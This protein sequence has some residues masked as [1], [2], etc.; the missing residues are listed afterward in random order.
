MSTAKKSTAPT[1]LTPA[2]F[3]V[4][5]SYIADQKIR[6]AVTQYARTEFR[7]GYLMGRLDMAKEIENKVA[8]SILAAR[9]AEI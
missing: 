3:D 4:I 2:A 1:P 5:V 7:R 6:E 9:N 8:S